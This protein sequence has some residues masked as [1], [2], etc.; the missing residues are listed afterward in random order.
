[1]WPLQ[2]EEKLFW[3]YSGLQLYPD[4][5]LYDSFQHV[6]PLTWVRQA[7]DRRVMRGMLIWR[8]HS[9]RKPSCRSALQGHGSLTDERASENVGKATKST[10][11]LPSA[12]GLLRV[13][14]KRM[15]VGDWKAGSSHECVDHVAPETCISQAWALGGGQW[16]LFIPRHL[17]T[18]PYSPHNQVGLCST[19]RKGES[20]TLWVL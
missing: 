7:V 8:G 16:S 6:D 12:H 17:Q 9:V 20:L 1:M 5:I 15:D 19:W 2:M 11:P 3:A 10:P 4:F 14:E 18:C 13:T